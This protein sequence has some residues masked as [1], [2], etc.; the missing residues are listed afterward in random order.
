MAEQLA[1]TDLRVPE[2]AGNVN[3]HDPSI[4]ATETG[5]VS[6]ATGIERAADGGMPRTKSSPDG[7]TW[8]ETGAI[9]GGL[10]AWIADE[11][12]YTP[13]NLWAPNIGIHD[14]SAYLYYA[15]SSF[16]RNNSII[17]LMTN[18]AFNPARPA[19]GWIDQGMV[20]R[21]RASDNFN[22]IDPFRINTSDGRSWLVFG[23]F[24]GGIR[25]VELDPATG[26]RLG[27]GVPLPIASRGGW[28]IE[29]PALLEHEG[30]FYLFVSFDLCC[31][32]INSTYRIMV[33]RA[34]RIEGPYR[35]RNGKPMLSGG[36][37]E[38]LK[39]TGRYV[40]PGGQEVFVADGQPWLAFH[41]YDRDQDGVP[42]L[43]LAPLDWSADGWPKLGSLPE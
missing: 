7:I 24:W 42:K 1:W 28:A 16:G 8:A 26:M 22:A 23:S 18:P 43:Q 30:G 25:L 39:T 6:F 21:S 37:T 34:D 13:L 33:G 32:G 31:R 40:G 4:I 10:P 38:L 5:W 9:P 36:G 14:G 19:E 20:Q 29:S 27:R 11:L 41:Y 2:L 17:G 35:D 12:G 15:A 3:L